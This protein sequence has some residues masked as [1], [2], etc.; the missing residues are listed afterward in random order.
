MESW[1][2]HKNKNAI[3]IYRVSSQK[4]SEGESLETQKNQVEKYCKDLGLKIIKP[5]EI[6][7]SAKN[8]DVRIKYITAMTWALN[9]GARHIVFCFS[10]REG[11]NLKDIENNEILVRADKIVLHYAQSRKVIHKNSPSADFMMRDMEA[12]ISK[13]FV[14]DLSERV[15]LGFMQKAEVGWYPTNSVPLGYITVRPKDEYGR[16]TRKQA[17]VVVDTNEKRVRQVQREFELRAEGHSLES[18]AKKII[19][20][21]FIAPNKVRSFSKSIIDR[22]L[23]NVFYRGKFKWKGI[24]YKGNHEIIIP[25]SILRAVD[26]T[27]GQRATLHKTGRGVFSG[28]WLRCDDPECNCQIIYDPKTKPDG[29]VFKYY[30]CSNSRRVHT[31]LRGM[32]VVEEKIW[33]QLEAVPNAINLTDELAE[34][35]SAALNAS[36]QK[37]KKAVSNEIENYRNAL[38]GLEGREDRAYENLEAGVLD[39]DSYKRQF[40][41][42]RSDRNELTHLL[43][44]AQHSINDSLMEDVKSILELAIDAKSLWKMRNHEERINFLKRVCSN[45]TLNESSVRYNLKKP[46]LVLSEMRES[47]NWCTRQDSNL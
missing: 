46:Y 27:L 19:E 29:R 32:W 6:I 30:R 21:G 11:R 16:D 26:A 12:V 38:K 35:I 28:G 31:S 4:Q 23:K 10:N 47:T 33:A 14:R 36:Q 25:T 18:I 20:E 5:F 24:E 45:A 7:E 43:E 34:D 15:S 13:N 42:I 44:K 17:T 39:S 22:R 1:Q 9:N 2:N 41:R 37:S 3:A 40:D 8:A